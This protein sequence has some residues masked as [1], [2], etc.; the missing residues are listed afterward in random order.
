MTGFQ[1]KRAMSVLAAALVPDVPNIKV[2]SKSTVDGEQWYTVRC[3]REASTWLRE[4]YGDQEDK[5]WFQNIDQNWNIS[6]N[7]F[8]VNEKIYTLL[9]LKWA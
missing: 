4:T 8:D 2:L 6:Y 7:I 1:S 9:T 3:W 5:M